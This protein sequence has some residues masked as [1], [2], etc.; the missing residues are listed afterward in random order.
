MVIG[1]KDLGRVQKFDVTDNGRL[2]VDLV[3]QVSDFVAGRT[4]TMI[5]QRSSASSATNWL[6]VSPNRLHLASGQRQRVTFRVKV[7]GHPEPGDHQ[8]A[9][10][11]FVPA[12]QDGPNIRLSRAIGTPIYIT[13]PGVVN[14]ATHLGDLRAP[15]FAMHGPISIAATVIDTGNVH[16]DFRRPAPLDVRVAGRTVPFPDFTVLRDSTREIAV[17][18]A[19]PPL[20]CICH[21][22]VAIPVPGGVSVRTVRIVIF[23]VDTAGYVL[24]GLVALLGL[25][26]LARWRYRGHIQAAA[27]KLLQ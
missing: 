10:L 9:L 11:F 1:P 7:S 5:L 21:A 12:A 8:V 26:L 27:R 14:S 15:G 2:P 18:W 4:G 25:G 13:A 23:P 24:G 6:T 22:T 20:M 17:K 19:N 16:R 3:V